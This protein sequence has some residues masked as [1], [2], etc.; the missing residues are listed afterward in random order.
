MGY[1]ISL[2]WLT[3]VSCSAVYAVSA[4]LLTIY[5]GPGA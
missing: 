5:V 3:F 2:G 4:A 1:E